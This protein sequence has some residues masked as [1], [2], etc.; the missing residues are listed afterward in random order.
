MIDLRASALCLALLGLISP[1]P[2]LSQSAVPAG[3]DYDVLIAAPDGNPIGITVFEPL[4]LPVGG[5]PLILL[6][7]GFGLTRARELD[8]PDAVEGFVHG[9]VTTEAA[10]RARQSGYYVISFDQR[11]FG[12]SAGN[13]TV[14]DPAIDGRNISAIIDWAQ[15]HLSGLAYQDNDL[16]LGALGLSYGGGFQTIGSA[17]DARFDAIVPTASWYDLTYSLAP[18]GVPKTVWLDLLAPTGAL[19]SGLRLEPYVYRAFLDSTLGAIPD[20]ELQPFF[21]HSPRAYCEGRSELGLRPP[22]VSAFFVQGA[23]DVLFNLNEAAA[24]RQ[25]WRRTGN[26]TRLLVVDQAHLL[27]LFQKSGSQVLFGVPMQAHCAGREYSVPQ[28]MVDFLDEKLRGLKP[29]NPV[30]DLCFSHDSGEGEVYADMPRGGRSFPMPDVSVLQGPAAQ[31]LG[32]AGSPPL[33]SVL[34]LLTGLPDRSL[35][36]LSSALTGVTDPTRFAE[37]LGALASV[38]P[39]AL[40]QDA[41]AAGRFVPLTS[42]SRDGALDGIPTA[43]LRLQGPADGLVFIGLGLQ[44]AEGGRVELINDQVLPVTGTGERAVDLAGVSRRVHGGD[45]LGLMVYGFHPYF[46]NRSLLEVTPAAVTVSGQVSLPLR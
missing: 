5:S 22:Q 10:R 3:R 43:R 21:Q 18:A 32:L 35:Q 31:A 36:L 20:T 26:D 42:V 38:A 45:T 27:P 23:S 41:T 1:A 17:V 40:V 4:Q 30:P 16:V 37:V 13:V 46:L 44:P 12:Q 14:M 24:L 9:D 7:H 34:D 15:Q 19:T 6:G 2:A 25:C 11:G 39:A 28:M 33:P 29:E 8:N